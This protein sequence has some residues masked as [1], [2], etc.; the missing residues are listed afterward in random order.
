MGWVAVY[1]NGTCGSSHRYENFMFLF[2]ASF[3]CDSFT[4]RYNR[5]ISYIF[6]FQFFIFFFKWNFS[7]VKSDSEI[8]DVN[9]APMDDANLPPSPSSTRVYLNCV[10]LRYHVLL[11]MLA[12]TP[13]FSEYIDVQH[14]IPRTSTVSE[15]CSHTYFVYVSF[16]YLI[17]YAIF[18]SVVI[19]IKKYFIDIYIYIYFDLSVLTSWNCF[20]YQNINWG[21]GYSIF[22]IGP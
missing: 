8:Y 7:R 17:L 10:C 5:Y 21:N 20:K 3:I 15:Y 18:H 9:Y 13:K 19:I 6:N 14:Y 1:Q 12:L 4:S 2:V 22:T 11:F 16:V